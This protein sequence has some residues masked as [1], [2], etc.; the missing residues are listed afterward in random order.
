MQPLYA[1]YRQVDPR[2]GS[3]AGGAGYALRLPWNFQP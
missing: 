2:H 1:D 3:R